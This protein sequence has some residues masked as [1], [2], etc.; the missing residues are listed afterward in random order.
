MANLQK[1]LQA[2]QDLIEIWTYTAEEWGEAQADKY[3]YKIESYFEKISLGK[4]SLKLLM[5]DVQFIRCEHHYIFVYMAKK[6]IVI[7]ILHE[8]MDLLARLKKRLS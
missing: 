7:A 3:L 5:E 4:A 6:P 1:T 2:E 8:K